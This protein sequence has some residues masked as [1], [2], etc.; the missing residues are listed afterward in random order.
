MFNHSLCRMAKLLLGIFFNLLV[1]C[2]RQSMAL[3]KFNFEKYRK[4]LQCNCKMTLIFFLR[5][6]RNDT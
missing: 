5:K 1:L 4:K 6:T 2:R 3:M